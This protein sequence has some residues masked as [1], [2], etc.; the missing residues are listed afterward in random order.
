VPQ[1]RTEAPE[2][3]QTPTTVVVDARRYESLQA[4]S[5]ELDASLKVTA[6]I[7]E[8][9]MALE[10]GESLIIDDETWQKSPSMRAWRVANPDAK[11][12]QSKGHV[13]IVV[14]R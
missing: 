14:E 13:V 1:D 11:A 8:R 5:R 4:R 2:Q 9:L 6:V 10:G 12:G 7:A 3:A